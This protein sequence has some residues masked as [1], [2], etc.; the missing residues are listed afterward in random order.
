MAR[1][2]YRIDSSS[3]DGLQVF[4]LHP[5]AWHFAAGHVPKLELLGQDSPYVRTSNGHVLDLGLRPPAPAA[6]PRGAGR[7][8]NAR[9][10]TS[11]L[12]AVYPSPRPAAGCVAHPC[13]RINRRRSHASRQRASWSRVQPASITAPTAPR[14]TAAAHERLAKV[15]RDDLTGPR[16]TAAAGSSSAAAGSHVPGP[17]H[18]PIEFLARG[19]SHWSLRLRL[20]AAWP[21]PGPRR[22][23]RS[24]LRHRQLRTAASV[25]SIR[26]A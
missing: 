5:G 2:V 20:G 1:G 23:G 8:P 11:P 14:S 21:L 18:R 10:V 15:Y 26:V 16:R 12:P 22:R 25:I 24:S 6:G 3:P 7:G 4:Q 19:T 13:S 9:D 17:A